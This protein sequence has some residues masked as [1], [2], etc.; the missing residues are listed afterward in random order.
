[1]PLTAQ[2]NR[3]ITDIVVI[4]LTNYREFFSDYH[5]VDA[6]RK[7]SL[8]HR[9]ILESWFIFFCNFFGGSNSLNVIYIKALR[10]LAQTGSSHSQFWAKRV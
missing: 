4:E 3:Q 7:L 9:I 6:T 5:Q 10:Q 1:M 8:I 2:M